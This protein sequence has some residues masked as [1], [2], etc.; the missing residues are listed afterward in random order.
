MKIIDLSLPIDDSVSETHPVQITRWE[1][2]SGGDRL[3]WFWARSQGIKGIIKRIT[4]KERITRD[5]FKD[6]LFLS[7]EWVRATVHSGTHLD[8]PYHFGPLSE[9]KEAKKIEDIPLEWCYSDG[10]VLDCSDKGGGE[11]ITEEDIK[12]AID[13]IKYKI[14]PFDIVLIR[15]GADR[16]WGTKLY[17]SRFPAMSWEAI[18]YIVNLGV[19]IIGIDTFNFDRPVPAMIGDFLRTKDNSYLWPAHFYGREKEY[20][21]IERLA[22]LGKIPQPY[23]FKVACFPIKIKET[24]AAWARVV[25]IFE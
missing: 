5:S 10:V 20:C 15:T 12:K 2:R 6:G 14:K 7:L 21:H 22:N 18:A 19:K 11:V 23:G 1:H 24:G 16:F 3:G 9:G 4:G 13:K 17:F 25:A 8:A